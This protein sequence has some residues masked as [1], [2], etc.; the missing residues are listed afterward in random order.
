MRNVSRVA[1]RLAAGTANSECSKM[2]EDRMHLSRPATNGEESAQKAGKN[3]A[4]LA[5]RIFPKRNAGRSV[6]AQMIKVGVFHSANALLPDVN[7]H[8][9]LNPSTLIRRCFA[10]PLRWSPKTVRW[11]S[12][13]RRYCP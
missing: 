11:R 8:T 13:H 6:S 1:L 2:L 5:N 9:D 4:R 7:P 10:A 3:V 12:R